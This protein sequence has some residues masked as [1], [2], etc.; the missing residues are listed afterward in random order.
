M[1]APFPTAPERLYNHSA[2][3]QPATQPQLTLAPPSQEQHLA[4]PAD[5]TACLGGRRSEDKQRP[6]EALLETGQEREAASPK[7]RRRMIVCRYRERAADMLR[8]AL[9][10]SL[11][12]IRL[13]GRY[14]VCRGLTGRAGG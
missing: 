11:D 7:G 4:A 5:P 6:F 3:A 14:G 1:L 9:A 12:R 2:P 8:P 10:S 13:A